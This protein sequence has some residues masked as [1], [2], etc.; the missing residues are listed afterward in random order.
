MFIMQPS[1]RTL[2]YDGSVTISEIEYNNKFIVLKRDTVYE[3]VNKP[4]LLNKSIYM[5]QHINV[6]N[7][8]FA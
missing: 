6:S 2:T 1:H 5:R 8:V 7:I 3:N 4:L